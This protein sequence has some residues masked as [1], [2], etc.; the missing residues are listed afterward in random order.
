MPF[1]RWPRWLP[2]PDQPVEVRAGAF[3]AEQVGGQEPAQPP[4]PGSQ[5][6]G[7]VAVVERS[8][9]GQV[10]AVFQAPGRQG[11]GWADDRVGVLAGKSAV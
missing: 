2:A 11:G 7:G 3:I 4:R 9:D 1:L 6:P 5:G 10:P 8:G